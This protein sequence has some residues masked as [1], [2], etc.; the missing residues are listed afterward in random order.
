MKVLIACEYS[1]TVREAF[2]ARGHVAWSCDLE[3]SEVPGNHFQDDVRT[4]LKLTKGWDL[5][6]AHPPCT[7]L[8][9][10]GAAFW[11]DQGRKEKRDEALAFFKELYNAPIN[12]VCI[13]NPHGY[14]RVAF[15]QPDQEIHPYYFGDFQMKRTLLWL[16][17]LPKL[18]HPDPKTLEK[19]KPQFVRKDGNKQYFCSTTR[20]GKERARFWPSIA[21][22]M[23]EQWG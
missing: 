4:V 23:A 22:A 5:M 1:A 17:G 6:I 3:P 14:P 16:R 10:A 2:N 11:N 18:K 13:E 12:K 21:K 20:K 8:S 15:R 7:Y 19:P 9:Y